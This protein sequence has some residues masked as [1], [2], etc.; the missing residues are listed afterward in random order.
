MAQEQE[1]ATLVF[2]VWG[3]REGPVHW[4]GTHRYQAWCGS[5]PQFRHKVTEGNEGDVTCPK[6]IRALRRGRPYA[7][8]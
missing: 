4:L 1:T 8:K 3:D 7:R 5:R 2:T 6:C